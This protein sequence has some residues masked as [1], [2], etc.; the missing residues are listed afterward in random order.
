MIRMAV[1]GR[2]WI[3][4]KWMDAARR[5]GN[6]E[7]VAAY[8]RKLEDAQAFARANGASLWFDSMEALC[9]C[10]SVDGVYIASPIFM[11]ARQSIQLLQA[12]KHV[13]IEKPMTVSHTNA[14]KMFQAAEASHVVLME[15]LRN[16]HTSYMQTI[17]ANLPKL[18]T[19]RK[20]RFSYCQYSSKFDAYKAG[21]M[22]NTFNAALGNGALMDLGVYL[23]GGMIY[24]FGM[25]L[26]L[27]GHSSFL[28]DWEASGTLLAD[29]GTL[30]VELSYSKIS[31]SALPSEIQGEAGTMVIDHFADGGR[32]YIRYR[33]GRL[34]ELEGCVPGISLDEETRDFFDMLLGGPQKCDWKA[35]SLNTAKLMEEA[36]GLLGIQFPQSVYAL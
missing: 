22:P 27:A 35:L 34:E 28:R 6:V 9:S 10:D 31:Q 5:C 26:S 33:D 8:S 20:A 21:Q 19:L 32:L 15:G 14:L 23:V 24:L 3:V 7:I 29:Y 25:P 11:H 30:Q 18:G 13:L 17:R 12:G 16:V 1:I 4:E 36:R 2:G